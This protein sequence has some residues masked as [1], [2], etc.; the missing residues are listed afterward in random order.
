MSVQL[1]LFDDRDPTEVVP[2][3]EARGSRRLAE[4]V[5]FPTSRNRERVRRLAEQLAPLSRDERAL[6]WRVECDALFHAR[7]HAGLSRQQALRDVTDFR[8]AVRTLTLFLAAR[9]GRRR[10]NAEVGND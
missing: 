5:P 9:P 10:P 8:D 6:R 4:V 1:D 7:L 3:P 2:V